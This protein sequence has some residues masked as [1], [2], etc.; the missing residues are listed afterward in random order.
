MTN[1][2]YVQEKNRGMIIVDVNSSLSWD[3]YA[4]LLTYLLIE[5]Y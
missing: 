3:D 1:V 4:Y 2:G 5:L